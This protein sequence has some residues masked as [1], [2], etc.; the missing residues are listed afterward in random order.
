MQA[1]ITK[2]Q[3]QVQMAQAKIQRLKAIEGYR[4]IT[5]PIT[6]IIQERMADPG[7]IV[8]A[9]MGILKIGDYSKVR[10]QAD[11]AQQN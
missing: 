2:A 11:V 7:V 1:Q 5:S 4:I 3:S 10:L 9:G 8:Q 6:G